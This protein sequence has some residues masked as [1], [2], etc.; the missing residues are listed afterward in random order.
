MID[1]SIFKAYDIRGAYPEQ[2]NED[3]AYRIGQAYAKLFAP[4]GK[5]AVGRDVRLHSEKLQQALINGLT[6]AGV[7]IVDIGLCSTDM[8]YFS[9][10]FY[11]LAG[12]IMVTASHNPAEYN[13]FKM[14]KAEV[15]PI[16]SENGIFAL[17]DLI[18]ENKEKTSAPKKGAV[19][20]K[21]V[22]DDFINFII[23]KFI[24][25]S[26]IKP[27]K[28]VYN[29]NFGFQGEV[30]KR[31][32]E[33][34]KIPIEIIGLNEKPNGA[35]P[36]GRPDPFIPENR[37]ELV[38]K[39][40]AESAALGVA[41][42]ADGDRV[43]F[44]TGSGIFIEPYYLNALL[45]K[46]MLAK[47]PGGKIIYDPRYTWALIDSARENNGVSILERVGHSFIKA[48]MRKEDACFSG[49]SSG[50]TYFRDFWYADAGMIPLLLILEIISAQGSLDNL[51]KPYLAKYFISGE[52][53]FEVQ[54]KDAIL[55]Q[56]EAKYHDAKIDKLDG[57]SIE[58]ENWRANIRPS[59]TEPLLRL[60]LEAKSLELMEQKRSELID[61]FFAKA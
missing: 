7:D 36:K 21:N 10:G 14:V 11:G 15:Q 29:P 16:S 5:I 32:I 9:V 19:E 38:E 40:Q 49:E 48:R 3:L 6:D 33:L 53:N 34:K 46:T 50:H 35:F 37:P 44:C 27:L 20:A 56:I 60:N 22:L 25:I 28:I 2:I 31:I 13:G 18:L 55:T 47:N 30:L 51:L 39:V 45:I 26:K 1:P 59:N 42:D 54:D 12:G 4:G 24:D 57:L 58:Y 23:E 61:N 17:R 43:F 52:Q 8:Y 41:W